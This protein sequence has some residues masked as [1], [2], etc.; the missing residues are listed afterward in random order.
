MK[1][2][3][4]MLCIAAMAFFTT[5]CEQNFF[6]ATVIENNV[7]SLLV[8]PAPGAAE[9]KSADRIIVSLQDAKLLD[10]QGSKIKASEFEVDHLVEITY[11]GSVAESYPAQINGTTEVRIKGYIYRGGGN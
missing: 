8:E 6:T 1:T 2:L 5:G 9:L 11:T 4:I 10:S 3:L 7:T